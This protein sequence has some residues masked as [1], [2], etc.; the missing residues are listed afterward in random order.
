MIYKDRVCYN[1]SRVAN[2]YDRYSQIQDLCAQKLVDFLELK[3][4]LRTIFDLGCGTGMFTKILHQKFPQ[5]KICAVDISEEMLAVAKNKFSQSNVN[6]VVADAETFVPNEQFDLVCSNASFQ[7]FSDLGKA[8]KHYKTMLN[9]NG[10]ILFSIFGPKTF[11]QLRESLT[12]L[13]QD[14]VKISAAQF[15]E[16]QDIVALLGQNY[17]SVSVETG[18][19]TQEFSSVMAMLKQIKYSGVRGQG[20]E[21]IVFWTPKMIKRLE[22][23]YL[24]LFG[25]IVATYEVFF[26][27]AVNV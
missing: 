2:E 23:I 11:W 25:K 7:W 10:T 3:Q 16:S 14:D 8:F 26:C 9:F 24:D 22:T 6:Y 1:F 21:Q 20:I 27:Q 19:Y 5:A 15:M 4:D 17:V 12:H 18:N 13:C